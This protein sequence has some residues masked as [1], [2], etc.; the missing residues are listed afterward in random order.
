MIA[1]EVAMEATASF[2]GVKVDANKEVL[3]KAEFDDDAYETVHLS[4]VH[5]T[6]LACLTGQESPAG[7]ACIITALCASQMACACA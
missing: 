4:Q 3:V 1:I 2:H 5:V 6:A 7:G